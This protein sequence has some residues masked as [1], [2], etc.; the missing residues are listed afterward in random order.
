M[1]ILFLCSGNTCRSCV[2]EALFNRY[3]DI[4]GITSESAGVSVIAGSKATQN[5]SFVLKDFLGID[6]SERK[7]VQLTPD[8]ILKADLVLTM[9]NYI[10]DVIVHK[11]PDSKSLVYTLNEFVGINGDVVDPF[12]GDM[13]IYRK[14]LKQ[15]NN[16]VLL[17]IEKLKGDRGVE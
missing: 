4:E 13:L 17:L 5:A 15:L 10:K 1:I 2:A 8:I 14:T 7:A 11:F 6:I 3:C 9:T 12:G 16:G